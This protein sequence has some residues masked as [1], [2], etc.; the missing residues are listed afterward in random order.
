MAPVVI[1]ASGYEQQQQRPLHR[2]ERE[3]VEY[4]SLPRGEGGVET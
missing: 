4:L 3:V 2:A 1:G